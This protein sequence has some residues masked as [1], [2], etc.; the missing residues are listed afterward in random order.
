MPVMPGTLD[1]VVFTSQDVQQ[2]YILTDSFY[3][4]SVELGQPTQEV[5][6]ESAMATLA[7]ASTESSPQV[8]EAFGG[9][10]MGAKT[11]TDQ[12]PQVSVGGAT[13]SLKAALK[14][15]GESVVPT[16]DGPSFD[17]DDMRK[18]H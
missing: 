13:L 6:T 16:Y 8:A 9:M 17:W 2:T 15:G 10:K 1:A 14:T 7:A 3:G 5:S 11:V 12:I 4:L 18:I